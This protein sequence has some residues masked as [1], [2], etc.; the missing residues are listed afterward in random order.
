MNSQ[1][2]DYHLT[3]EGPETSSLVLSGDWVQGQDSASFTVVRSELANLHP[4]QLVA[5][6]SG[7]GAW[8]SVL[9]AFLLQCH[10]YCRAQ[11]IAFSTRAMP[12]GI[13]KLLKPPKGKQ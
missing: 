3:D 6:G 9:M 7:L 13:E 5:D 1:P 10:D 8:D 12:E 2:P 11:G 4:T